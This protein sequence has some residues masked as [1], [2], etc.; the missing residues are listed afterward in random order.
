MA[1]IVRLHLE[2]MIPELEEF[3]SCSIFTAAEV[4]QIVKN[5]S[6]FEYAL[7]RHRPSV[8]DF[9]RYV[10]YEMNL[11]MLH[12]KR[13]ERVPP[14]VWKNVVVIGNSAKRRIHAIFERGIKKFTADVGLWLLFIEWEMKHGSANA[15]STTFAK[16]IKLHPTKPVIWVRAAQWEYENNG[17][18][19]ASRVLF[20]RGLRVNHT[21][22]ILWLGFFRTEIAYLEKL[23]E[24]SRVLGF[25]KAKPLTRTEDSFEHCQEKIELEDE[26]CS[27][28]ILG[29]M[30]AE[31][32]EFFTGVL[33]ASIYNNAIAAVP[34]D[35]QFRCK[36][37]ELIPKLDIY[38]SLR[39]LVDFS[40][41][42]DFSNNVEMWEI[43][44][45][46]AIDQAV[47]NDVSPELAY[48]SVYE[49]A[50]MVSNAPQVFE[51]YALFL[52]QTLLNMAE[53]EDC[54]AE[55][56]EYFGKLQ[57]NLSKVAAD[58]GVISEKLVH[59]S[60]NNFLSY[61]NLTEA[62]QALENGLQ[63]FSESVVLIRLKLS[64]TCKQVGIS[65]NW[66]VLEELLTW[67]EAFIF[68]NLPKF[69]ILIDD[70]VELYMHVHLTR[71]Y[72][73]AVEDYYKFLLVK[74][75]PFD[76]T[77]YSD[78]LCFSFLNFCL[79]K[80]GLTGWRA[81]SDYLVSLPNFSYRVL[82][83]MIQFEKDLIKPQWSKARID[84]LFEKLV[85]SFGG[86]VDCWISYLRHLIMNDPNN[87]A[88]IYQRGL[89]S[90]QDVALFMSE[91][92]RIKTSF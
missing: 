79:S 38:E 8:N 30:L 70:L 84:F 39:Q 53:N 23:K 72:K 65:G 18:I 50:I 40:L 88:F 85:G 56:V 44:A 91:Y 73:T 42:R 1:D 7:A 61:G 57:L 2:A 29:G 64:L 74:L 92:E 9:L 77:N 34:N 16:A 59:F 68:S 28:E 52:D 15:L 71:Q 41:I 48:I 35:I 67:L 86:E 37:Y 4:R 82:T 33:A 46:R 13:R 26:K 21:A 90:V 80:K 3:E 45:K 14:E 76:V 87:V 17:N 32:D 58:K 20:Q 60:V 63:K 51:R 24:R 5:R 36:F 78:Q 19:E 43:M 49:Q 66:Q 89:K 27:E 10:Q 83:S 11:D 25:V 81:A 47:F 75:V 22:D 31:K 54:L 69:S 62:L 6:R 55:S 12:R